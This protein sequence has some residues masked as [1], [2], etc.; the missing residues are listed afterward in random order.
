MRRRLVS[1]AAGLA[2]AGIVFLLGLAAGATGV[3][4]MHPTVM[5]A[6]ARVGEQVATFTVG[7]TSYG[8]ASS[9]PWRD[10]GG[11]EHEGG[12]P[13]CLTPGAVNGVRFTGAVV[14]NGGTT[15][16]A[17]VLWVDCSGH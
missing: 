15:S 6:D 8:V 16:Y 2:V 13:A 17:E 12:W 14:S 10:A 11:T 1:L 3:A 5:T 4:G 7:A 9:V